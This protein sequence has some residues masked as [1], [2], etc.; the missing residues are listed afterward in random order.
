MFE[1]SA[2]LAIDPAEGGKNRPVSFE[3]PS[4]DGA[5]RPTA[6]DEAQK[7]FL[8]RRAG[9]SR[10]APP[11]YYYAASRSGVVPG[12]PVHVHSENVTQV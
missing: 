6:I 1:T 9:E 5:T 7:V 8:P 10:S 12:S 4:M 2:P 11:Q 3:E